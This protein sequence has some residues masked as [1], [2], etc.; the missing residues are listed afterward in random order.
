MSV[1]WEIGNRCHGN[2]I[3]NIRTGHFYGSRRDS[4][5]QVACRFS[6]RSRTLETKGWFTCIRSHINECMGFSD[7]NKE[8][9][10]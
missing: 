8:Q 2:L 3:I 4:H 7:S 1:R 6:S 10:P 5:G 9:S